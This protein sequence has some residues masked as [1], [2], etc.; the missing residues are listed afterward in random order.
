[1]KRSCGDHD[2]TSAGVA[3]LGAM[4]RP[5]SALGKCFRPADIE[6]ANQE[7]A[8]PHVHYPDWLAL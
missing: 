6:Q 1:M 4:S 5:C 7:P 3:S 8:L 2:R